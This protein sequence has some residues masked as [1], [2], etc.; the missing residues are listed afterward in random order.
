MHR[1]ENSDA[2]PLDGERKMVTAPFAGIRGST[3]LMEDLH[4]EYA[5]AIVNRVPKLMIDAVHRDDGYIVRSTGDAISSGSL[6]A[7]AAG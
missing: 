6:R 2:Q 4:P 5:R 7:R 1:A 3:E